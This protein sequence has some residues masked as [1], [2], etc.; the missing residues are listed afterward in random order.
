MFLK[1]FLPILFLFLG[2][3]LL[4]QKGVI[5][6]TV[7]DMDSKGVIAD[8]S[9]VVEKT[10]LVA[11]TNKDG[12]FTI[13]AV[14]AG[15]YNIVASRS[16]Y[17]PVE[18]SV[19]MK[20]GAKVV[21]EFTMKKEVTES[22]NT[23]DLPSV[24][25]DQADANTDG[26]GEVANLL[27]SSRDI[28]QNLSGFSWSP[29]RFRERGYDSENFPV[30]LNG[31]EVNDP[32]TGRT[33]FGEFGGLNDVLRG[34]ESVV[35]LDAAEFAFGGLGGASRI[36][37]RA[38]SQ[39]KQTRASYAITN[40][41][42]RNRIML[43]H[44]TGMM[45]G[46]WAISLSASHRWAHE[47]YMQGTFFQGT[48]YFAS[49]DKKIGT[50]HLVNLTVLGA[51]SIS[52]RNGDSFVEM[53]ELAGTN[54]YNPSWGYQNG[55]KRN[56]NVARNNQPMGI[57]S[58][59][60]TPS[61]KTSLNVTAFGQA[62]LSSYT[63]L[64]WNEATNPAPDYHRRIPSALSDST[65][66]ASWENTLRNNPALLQ[67]NWD[68]FFLANRNSKETATDGAGNEITGNRSQYV[69]EEQ[70]SDSREFGANIVL[71]QT[72]T[73]R[74]ILNAGANY[75]YYI[76][77]NFKILNDLLGGDFWL[78]IN[79]YT[80]Q[81]FPNEPE[82]A[83]NNLLSPSSLIKKGDRFGYDYDE[84]IRKSGAWL[85]GQFSSKH[86]QFFASGSLNQTSIWRTGNFKHGSFPDNSLGDSPKFNYLNYGAKAGI[87][88]KM[89]GRNYLYTNGY[90]GTQA[91]QFRDIFKAPRTRNSIFN[92]VD[93][94]KITSIEGGYMLRNPKYKGRATGYLT[95][96]ENEVENSIYFFPT[97]NEFGTGHVSGQNRQ[98]AGVELALEAKPFISWTFSAAAS[99]GK[100]I[101]T[102]R[103]LF[104]LSID[105]TEAFNSENDTV[106]QKN[107]YV[108][109]TPQNLFTGVVRYDGKNFWSAFV[110]FNY[111]GKFWYSFNSERHTL[112]AV[113]GVEKGTPGWNAIL[114]QKYDPAKY[115]IDLS[116]TKS[117]RIKSGYFVGLNAGVNNILN[118]QKIISSGRDA[119]ITAYR[120]LDDTR[121]YS[122]EVLYAPGINYFIGI[123]FRKQ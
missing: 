41:N 44:N 19:N 56:A 113:E 114:E 116:F 9:I 115:T 79:R 7:T 80:L 48:S 63:R 107:Y 95:R 30:Y 22:V 61:L 101:Y 103:P 49:I 74:I 25:L 102:N 75:R 34:R 42:Y 2:N 81:D 67:L 52:G 14:K 21:V 13:K 29:F 33:V 83:R 12:M 8:V 50:K 82:K 89:N 104:S 39:R 119:Y 122:H 31:I 68:G 28:F 10:G 86:F 99:I 35:G 6:G 11:A 20:K 98:H 51:P 55:E 64:E 69:V 97:A 43:T 26:E 65:Q 93:N 62:G 37:L 18:K 57:L 40:R 117:Y 47:G 24:T 17:S 111:R 87:V 23:S 38:S 106:Y 59:D 46:G 36:D 70:R 123:N 120:E 88:Y 53:Y 32:E 54:K 1:K 58:Y 4:A 71:R 72:I 108:K 73:P 85:Q 3:L 5:Q 16:G 92:D 60:W 105:N 118:N 90:M 66:R 45:K 96:F 27:N 84:N 109:R 121:R 110:T 112:S 78:D 94:T 77:E 100:Y 15:K 76:G 91:P